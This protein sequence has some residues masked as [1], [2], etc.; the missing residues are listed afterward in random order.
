M[1]FLFVS[2]NGGGNLP[3]MFRTA[4][5]LRLNGHAVDFAGQELITPG[6]NSGYATLSERCAERELTFIPMERAGARWG[7][8]PPPVRIASALMA[9][10]EQQADLAEV[11]SSGGYDAVIVDCM[12]F[13]ALTA[14]TA[15]GLPVGIFVHSAPG[16]L[17]APGGHL[18]T[19]AIDPVNE[20]RRAAGR[21][22]VHRLWDT[23]A[24]GKVIC[25][26]IRDL[27][28]R[29]TDVPDSFDF[30]GPV[31][32]H[33]PVSGW[34][35]PWAPDDSRPLVLVSFTTNPGWDQRSRIARTITA[36]AGAPY[37]VLITASLADVG[38]SAAENVA[39]VRRVPHA[40]V[41]PHAAVAVTHA[42]HGT[43]AMCLAHGVPLVSLPNPAADQPPLAAQVQTLG[44]GLALNGESAS[45]A[46]I[47]SAV[48][49]VVRTQ[50][51]RAVAGALAQ[52]IKGADTDVRTVAFCEALT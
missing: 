26:S 28:P 10:D 48:T 30:V 37:R 15:S 25:A 22:P 17:M 44:A 40:E 35:S 9:C 13:A 6:E 50:S 38:D 7:S 27:D 5:L 31:L 49:E 46:E 47:R 24:E 36:L 39:V 20:I 12:M 32:E 3:P 43:I 21:P 4:H 23:W 14:A 1:R 29:G 18:E 16:A 33:E 11:L 45:P 34:R 2:W 41:L 19:L 42:G 52:Q 51:Y 8:E